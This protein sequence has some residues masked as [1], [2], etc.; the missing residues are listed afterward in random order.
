MLARLSALSFSLGLLSC[1]QAPEARC[2]F[3]DPDLDRDDDGDGIVAMYELGG[4]CDR[5]GAS[6]REHSDCDLDGFSNDDDLD[7]DGDGI[8]DASEIG[9]RLDRCHPPRDTDGDGAPD[10]QDVDSDDDGLSDAE[11]M[12]LGTNRLLPDSDGD[13]CLDAAEALLGGCDDPRDLVMSFPCRGSRIPAVTF[14]WSGAFLERATLN[15]RVVAPL[16]DR[17]SLRASAEAVVPAGSAELVPNTSTE[18]MVFIN[19]QPG[20]ELVH[21]FD[22]IGSHWRSIRS[23]GRLEL[24]GPAGE[25]LDEGRVL[26]LGP[27][28]CRLASR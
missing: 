17:F 8:P 12:A 18:R 26:I 21:G 20:A 11:E 16:G 3:L 10:F 4:A 13:G 24:H 2:G 14:A 9:P 5:D 22:F 15:A 23:E 1:G 7:A 28:A 27:G 25:L 6:V 19:V